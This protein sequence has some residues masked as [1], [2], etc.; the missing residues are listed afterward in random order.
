MGEQELATRLNVSESLL[1]SWLRGE[2]AMPTKKLSALAEVLDNWA[3]RTK[4]SK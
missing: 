1:Q 4:S 2:V 3:R